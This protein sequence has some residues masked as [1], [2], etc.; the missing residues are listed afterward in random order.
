MD[1]RSQ[2]RKDVIL[3]SSP[4]GIVPDRLDESCCNGQINRR[5]RAYD[6]FAAST[7]I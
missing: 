7:G 4:M 2:R 6:P 3:G 1:A 5:C